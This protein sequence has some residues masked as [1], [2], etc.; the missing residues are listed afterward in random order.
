MN[1]RFS[2]FKPLKYLQFVTIN[3]CRRPLGK[4]QVVMQLVDN[5][6]SVSVRILYDYLGYSDADVIIFISRN[7]INIYYPF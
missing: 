1:L 3:V 4:M 6:R 2:S 7:V 5:N